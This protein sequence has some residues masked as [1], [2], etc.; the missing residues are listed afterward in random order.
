VHISA[1]AQPQSYLPIGVVHRRPTTAPVKPVRQ[2]RT[3]TARQAGA[4]DEDPGPKLLVDLSLIAPR[5]T[6]QAAG[7]TTSPASRADGA[8]E[9]TTCARR[10]YQ[11]KSDDPSVSF[12]A[13]TQLSAAEAEVMVRVHEQEHVRHE[14]AKAER[15]GKEVDTRVTIHYSVCPECGRVYCSGGTTRVATRE[16]VDPAVAPSVGFATG[17]PVGSA[18]GVPVGSATGVDLLA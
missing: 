5:P 12:Q 8:G 10:R 7:S 15:E 16:A 6:E 9:C 1:V 2:E 4:D 17:V 13:P 14:T 3:S 11:D 18:T